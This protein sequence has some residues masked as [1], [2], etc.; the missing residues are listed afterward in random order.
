MNRGFAQLV[1]Y[2]AHPSLMPLVGITFI[3]L[4]SPHY[5]SQPLFLL[6]ILYTFLGT[7]LFPFIVVAAMQ[8]LG[9]IK[10]LHM[11]NAADRRLPFVSAGL[12]YFLTAQALRNF[13]LPMLIPQYLFAGVIILGFSIIVLRFTKISIHAAGMGSLAALIL[14]ISNQ[15]NIQLLLPI[16]LV[17]LVGGLVATAR[18]YLAAH[19]PLEIYLGYALGIGSAFLSFYMFI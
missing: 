19:K 4:L 12:F 6:I 9:V 8:R 13:P 3:L 14:F 2:I 10:S 1:S 5:V 11:K 15:Y 7:Y 18:L 17:I 16:A